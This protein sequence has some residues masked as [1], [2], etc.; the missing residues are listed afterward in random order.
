METH[1]ANL[2]RV[3]LRL[4]EAVLAFVAS[5]RMQDL[6]E[7]HADELRDYCERHAAGAPG[8]PDR[9]LRDLRQRGLVN[10]ELVSRQRS[11]YRIGGA[12]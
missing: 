8:S 10:Y 9:I 6:P 1:G 4:S 7:F 12:N 11:L 5:R 3:R 2:E